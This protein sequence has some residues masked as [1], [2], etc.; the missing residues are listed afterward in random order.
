MEGVSST[1]AVPYDFSE[2]SEIAVIHALQIANVVNNELLLLYCNEESGLFISKS[3]ICEKEAEINSKFE[4]VIEN[5]K[6]K[7]NFTNIKYAFKSGKPKFILKSIFEEYNVALF[8]MGSSYHSETF[9]TNPIEFVNLI[10][11]FNTPVIF[12]KQL[13]I[14]QYY[15]ELVVPVEFDKKYKEEL[16]W[17]IFL[18]K[19]YKCNVNLIRENPENKY[20]K[21]H[22]ENNVYFTKKM[23]DANKI[24][25][26]L[27]MASSEI[28]FK[29]SIDDFAHSIEADL[30]I[31]MSH[32][33]KDYACDKNN[34]LDESDGT[35]VMVIN[36]RADLKNYQGFY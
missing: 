2:K 8:V 5:I 32:K 27:K 11:D 20:I 19:Y 14:N 9:E 34:N 15:R 23:L 16:K 28:N 10:K 31:I 33:F 22:I 25:Y 26:G 24:I 12:T 6:A 18:A 7:H 13:P 21:K 1:I 17:I 35:S 29:D 36:P 30:I 3:K 4:S